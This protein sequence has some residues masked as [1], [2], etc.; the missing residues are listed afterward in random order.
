MK[1]ERTKNGEK[2]QSVEAIEMIEF[3]GDSIY[4]KRYV[5]GFL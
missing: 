3:T 1:D 5:N 2:S 4:V